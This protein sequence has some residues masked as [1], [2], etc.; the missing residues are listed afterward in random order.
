MPIVAAD[1]I[2]RSAASVPE[3][4]TST[5]GGALSTTSRPDVT[6]LTANSVIAVVSDGVDTRTV[7]IT[8]RNAAG[9]VATE[10][11]VLAG[12]TEVVGTSTFERLLKIDL[13]AADAARTVTVR[14]GAGGATRATLTPNETKRHIFFQR[15]AS[16]AAAASRY[17][18][19]FWENAHA[20]LTLNDADVT[21]TADPSAKIKIALATAKGDAGSV[22]NRKTSPG[23]TFSDDNVVLTVPT[24]LLAAGEEI[25]VWV[26]QALLANDAAYRS[27]FTT[28]LRGTTV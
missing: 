5:A 26:E 9:A 10:A 19:L 25:G 7:T 22:A 18:K 17:E 11:L 3:N 8:G 15:S 12:A 2:A 1:L 21:L 4:D 28:R 14:Q 20:T 27:T 24:G 13:S 23:L 16:E 6:Q